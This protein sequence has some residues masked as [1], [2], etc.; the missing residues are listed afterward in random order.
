MNK[1]DGLRLEPGEAWLLMRP[2]GTELVIRV[3]AES[4]SAADAEMVAGVARARVE[5]LVALAERECV[6]GDM[7]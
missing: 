1:T 4:A 3:T 2:S 6:S 5:E 7:S